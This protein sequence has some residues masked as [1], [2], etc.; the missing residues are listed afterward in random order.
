MQMA[1]VASEK[2]AWFS[3]LYFTLL[4][5]HFYLLIPSFCNEFTAHFLLTG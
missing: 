4:G 5:K 2:G 3:D 1:I